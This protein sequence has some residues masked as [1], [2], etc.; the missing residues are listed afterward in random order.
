MKPAMSRTALWQVEGRAVPG[1]MAKEQHE[2]RQH[3][4]VDQGQMYQFIP[5]GLT[6]RG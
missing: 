3:E 5:T 1:Q 6:A 2:G 4:R